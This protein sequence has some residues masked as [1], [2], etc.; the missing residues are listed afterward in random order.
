M[1]SDGGSSSPGGDR[2][3]PLVVDLPA[4]PHGGTSLGAILSPIIDKN[5]KTQI[6]NIITKGEAKM[7]VTRKERVMF[8][9]WLLL[10]LIRLN[11]VGHYVIRN[12]TIS[13][14]YGALSLG[15]RQGHNCMVMS[16]RVK[17][18]GE[19]GWEWAI[20]SLNLSTYRLLGVWVKHIRGDQTG[21]HDPSSAYVFCTENGGRSRSI[22]TSME[23]FAQQKH[24]DQVSSKDAQAVWRVAA[25]CSG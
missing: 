21:D 19:M 10:N 15:Q 16:V 2:A 20:I 14:Y 25:H 23:R 24:F 4:P 22:N 11:G 5:L 3:V 6:V 7:E 12:M 13:D 17:D 8:R 18:Q 9:D 1:P